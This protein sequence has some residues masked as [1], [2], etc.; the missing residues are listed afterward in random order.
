MKFPSIRD[1]ASILRGIHSDGIGYTDSGD[2]IE[3]IDVRLQVMPDG[4]WEVH[5]GDSQYDTDHRGFWGSS[6]VPATRGRWSSVAVARDLLS[7]CRDH[8]AEKMEVK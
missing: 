3:T 6:E 5:S 2:E 8:R 4:A 7:Q 1:V